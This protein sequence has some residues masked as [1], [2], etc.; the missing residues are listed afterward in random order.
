MNVHDHVIPVIS[1]S[2]SGYTLIKCREWTG[3]R[4]PSFVVGIIHGL[5]EHSQRYTHVAKHF[6]ENNAAVYA[7]DQRGHGL[8]GGS[9][10]HFDT[11]VQDTGALESFL[12]LARPG[13]PIFL[14]GQSL[15]GSV[16]INY[17][18]RKSNRLAGAISMSPLLSTTFPPPAWKLTVAKLLGRWWPN[19]TL[20][21]ALKP[22][23]LSHDPQAVAEYVNDPMVHQRVSAV[24]GLS[25]LEAGRW[26]VEHADQLK[27]PLL[28]MHGTEDKI[29]SHAKSQEFAQRAGEA[30]TWI[31][32]PG[33][34]HDMHWEPQRHRL[35]ETMTRFI[36]SRIACATSPAG[37]PE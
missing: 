12:R 8:T 35:F 5:G 30:C 15:G 36:E 20:S 33:L 19:L 22:E 28:L 34:Y 7:I 27:T 13:L 32:W 37:Q 17:L 2:K 14:Y 1:D 3:D 25:M 4:S 21:T 6:V 31:E 11:L 9:L 18:L 29:T 16:V 23:E 10:P 26:A 24:L